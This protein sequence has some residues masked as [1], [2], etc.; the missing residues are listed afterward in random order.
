MPEEKPRPSLDDT[1]RNID[2][3]L[4]EPPVITDGRT[5]TVTKPGVYEMTWNPGGTGEPSIAERAL[6]RLFG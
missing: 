5:F 6:H 3:A 1:L 4:A 2:E